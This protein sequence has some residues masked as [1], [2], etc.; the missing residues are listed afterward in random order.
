MR[1][2]FFYIE[3]RENDFRGLAPKVRME[4]QCPIENEWGC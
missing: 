2:A 4:K 1:Y 3:K